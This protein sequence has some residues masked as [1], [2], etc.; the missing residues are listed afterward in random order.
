MASV[1]AGLTAL[2]TVAVVD[3]QRRFGWGEAWLA[4]RCGKP[5][6]QLDQADELAFQR[7]VVLAAGSLVVLM[8][9]VIAATTDAVGLLLAVLGLW[10]GPLLGVFLLGLLTRRAT[11][12]AVLLGAAAGLAAALWGLWG[13]RLAGVPGMQWSWPFGGP[14][15]RFWPFLFA[16][17]ATLMVGYGLSFFLGTRKNKEELTGLVLG[18][19]PLGF[20]VDDESKT[21]QVVWLDDEERS[22]NR[23][24]S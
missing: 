10:G 1:A 24:P 11:G 20:L 9:I 17:L 14:L 16:L 5:P 21:E 12:K 8:A 19:G 4:Q 23:G 6:E 2:A 15:G 18:L 13:D 22:V 3:C 7:P